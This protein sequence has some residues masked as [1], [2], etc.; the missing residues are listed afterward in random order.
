MQEDGKF[1]T[2]VTIIG[3]MY[4]TSFESIRKVGEEGKV[5]LLDMKYE[6]IIFHLL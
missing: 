6:V 2:M 5:C 4:G 3:N 1:I